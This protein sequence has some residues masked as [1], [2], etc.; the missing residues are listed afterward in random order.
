[1]ENPIKM[2]D[3][4]VPWFLE[5]PTKRWQIQLQN[6]RS[7]DLFLLHFTTKLLQFLR[8]E[9]LVEKNLEKV[10]NNHPFFKVMFFFGG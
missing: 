1:M 4:G 9:N 7:G 3:L 8:H 10:W 2:D 6:D 5:T